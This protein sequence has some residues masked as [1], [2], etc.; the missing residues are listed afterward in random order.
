MQGGSMDE[1]RSKIISES[2]WTNV[3]LNDAWKL[4]WNEHCLVRV[5]IRQLHDRLNMKKTLELNTK[6][7]VCI[8]SHTWT[9][10][11]KVAKLTQV[12]N[13]KSNGK[14]MS[15]MNNNKKLQWIKADEKPPRSLDGEVKCSGQTGKTLKFTFTNR[16]SLYMKTLVRRSKP[17][18]EPFGWKW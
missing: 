8:N 3:L 6:C 10:W 18:F 17:H 12:F 4:D 7:C 13:N 11:R 16:W 2:I 9:G 1:L 5:P 15:S 14:K